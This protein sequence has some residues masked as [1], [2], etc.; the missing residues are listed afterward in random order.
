MTAADSNHEAE[1]VSSTDDTSADLDAARSE[2]ADDRYQRLLEHSPDAI[3][4]HQAGRVVYVNKAGVRWIAPPSAETLVGKVITVFVHADSVPALRERIAALR[5]QGDIS[6]PSEAIM[7][8]FDGSVIDVEAVSVLTV[9]NGE[10]AY[11][12][13]FRDIS[14]RREA[15]AAL[16]FQA[17][18]VDHASDAIIATTDDGVVTSWN[19]AAQAI[20]RRSAAVALGSGVSEMVGAE[21]NPSKIVASGGSVRAT[22]YASDGTAL[23]VRVS[24]ASMDGGYVLLCSDQTALRRA[25]QHFQTVVRSLDEGVVVVDHTGRLIS[26][27]PAV[28]RVLGLTSADDALDYDVIADRWTVDPDAVQPKTKRPVLDT[29]VTGR[30]YQGE[31]YSIGEDGERRWLSVTSRRLNPED[32]ERSS[33]LVTF[34]DITAVRAATERFAHQALHDPLTGLPNRA[35]LVAH[36]ERL[37]ARGELGGVLF[38]DLDDFKIINDTLG[39]DAGDLVIQLAGQRIR[40]AVRDSDVVC[41]LAGDEFVVLLVGTL[42]RAELAKLSDRITGRLAEPM[43]LGATIVRIRGSIG[44]VDTGDET[45]TDA[46]TLLRRADRAMYAA[47]ARSRRARPAGGHGDPG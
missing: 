35:H 25:E 41:R 1:D 24:A 21:L 43:P 36:V 13:I 33:V 40:E 22:H 26:V 7:L 32:G 31:V 27:N 15:Q 45:P 3:C 37:L 18:L 4:V 2:S 10:P 34:H 16:R 29:L 9:W 39:H 11:Q 17:A 5:K 20:Y 38:V 46:A 6:E 42:G 47:K 44:V 28:R 23:T 30:P 19:P 14:A 8:R 12:V